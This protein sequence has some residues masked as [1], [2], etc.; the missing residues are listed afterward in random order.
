MAWFLPWVCSS[1][2]H[3]FKQGT[4]RRK[5][6]VNWKKA[7]PRLLTLGPVSKFTFSISCAC[8]FSPFLVWVPCAICLSNWNRAVRFHLMFSGPRML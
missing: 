2:F 6:D 8:D 7:R 1:F 3:T 4:R 5:K